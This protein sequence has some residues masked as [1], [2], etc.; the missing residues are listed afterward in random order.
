[1]AKVLPVEFRVA[2]PERVKLEGIGD[3]MAHP[4][5]IQDL[6]T[7]RIEGRKRATAETREKLKLLEETGMATPENKKELLTLL[8]LRLDSGQAVASW[9]MDHEGTAFSVW[10]MVRKDKPE[11]SCEQVEKAIQHHSLPYWQNL[12]DR[13][14]YPPSSDEESRPTDEKKEGE[15]KPDGEGGADPNGLTPMPLEM[16]VGGNE[17]T[18]K[19]KKR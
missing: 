10:L 6:G 14:S 16:R 9:M 7:L 5:N 8:F 1:M 17:K 3:V 11:I 12:I 2:S 19:L 13:L 18:A 4:L 15:K